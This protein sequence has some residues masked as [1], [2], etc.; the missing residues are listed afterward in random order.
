MLASQQI[1]LVTLTPK[2]PQP[3]ISA[4][5]VVVHASTSTTVAP[6]SIFDIYGTNFASSAVT[7]PPG[8][9][10]LPTILGTTQ[11]LV[12]GIPAP[13]FYAG[14]AQIVAQIP[15][16]ILT[17]TASVVVV[18]AGAAS[19]PVSV[20]VQ[21]AAPSILTYGTNRAIV[22]NQDYSL[23]SSANPAQSGSFAV[24]YVVGSGP[25]SPAIPD[26][27]PAPL[28]P[29]SRETLNTTVTVGGM[30]AQVLFAGMA[31]EFVGLVQIN[32]QVPDLPAGNYPIEVVVGT[33]QSNTP[34]MTVG[35]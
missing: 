29:L 28:S 35:P 8:A 2:A 12:N 11:V 26:G 24:A 33:A 15:G 18:N 1:L 7:A 13:L 16:A 23:N 6:G 27:E 25:V 22:E 14:P 20:T 21:Q 10:L 32:F 4:G 34:A 5:G 3:Q 17:G 30:P 9:Q 19:A 31:P